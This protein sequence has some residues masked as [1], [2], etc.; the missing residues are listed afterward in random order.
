MRLS[1]NNEIFVSVFLCVEELTSRYSY[2]GCEEMKL[3]FI[4]KDLKLN[5][6]S[7]GYF[8]RTLQKTRG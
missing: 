5:Q 3:K 8:S 4:D 1:K 6:R 2:F 7:H